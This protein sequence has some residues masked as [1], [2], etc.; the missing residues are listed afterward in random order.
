MHFTVFLLNTIKTPLKKL[1]RHSHD[2]F[3]SRNHLKIMFFFHTFKFRSTL[4]SDNCIKSIPIRQVRQLN[5]KTAETI[6]IY[7]DQVVYHSQ[8]SSYHN[9]WSSSKGKLITSLFI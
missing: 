1:I 7:R 5:V 6:D 2:N 8:M 9:I 3:I 4:L